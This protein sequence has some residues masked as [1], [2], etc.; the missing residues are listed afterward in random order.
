MP[1]IFSKISH[2]YP[3]IS[4]TT[5]RIVVIVTNNPDVIYCEQYKLYEVGDS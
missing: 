2:Y 5:N 4:S 3:T 1:N